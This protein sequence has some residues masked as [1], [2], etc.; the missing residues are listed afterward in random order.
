MDIWSLGIVLIEM[1]YIN[2]VHHMFNITSYV[3]T[4]NLCKRKDIPELPET[5]DKKMQQIIKLCLVYKSKDRA[6]AEEVLTAIDDIGSSVNIV[7]KAVRVFSLVPTML[8]RNSPLILGAA[9][10]ALNVIFFLRQ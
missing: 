3:Y 1:Y 9:S 5:A 10:I 6:T 7:T 8:Y 2:P 4:D